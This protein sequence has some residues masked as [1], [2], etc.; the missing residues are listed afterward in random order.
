M[1]YGGN[2]EG[3]QQTPVQHFTDQRRKGE[4]GR[5]ILTES[6]SEDH[7]VRTV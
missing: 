3:D 1:T 4:R 6:K 7:E 5:E 2:K